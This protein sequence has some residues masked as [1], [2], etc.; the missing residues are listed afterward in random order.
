[1]FIL[2]SI[3]GID[4]TGCGGDP[5]SGP[6]GQ[7]DEPDGG[8]TLPFK[9]AKL[10]I[11]HN[12]T[13]EDTGFQLFVDGEPW[14]A[15]DVLAPDG[16]S[17]LRIRPDGELA[18]LGLTELFLE[19]NEPPNAEVP[20][21]DVL[22]Q[23]P[24]GAYAVK[25]ES[26]DGIAMEGTA[27]LSHAIPAGPVITSPREGATVNPDDLV[28]S[29]NPVTESTTG[30]DVTIAAYELI[31]E[32]DVEPDPHAFANRELSIHV[33]PSVTS[34]TVPKEFL[35]PETPYLFEVLAIE[36]GGAQTLSSGTFKTR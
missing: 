29:W 4:A 10:L 22:A 5:A 24:E 9:E 15:L 31:V 7:P 17:L 34:L 26:V 28:I 18:A 11:E 6:T 1:M 23:L 8:A 36:E 21:S 13:D 30:A 35:E 2:G 16:T 20:M 27:T 33:S 19:T 25:G 32:E 12:A 14:K 3:A